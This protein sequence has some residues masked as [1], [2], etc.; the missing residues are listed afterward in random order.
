M[1]VKEV[2]E[3]VFFLAVREKRIT[4]FAQGGSRKI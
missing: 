3:S 1:S 2:P 4:D